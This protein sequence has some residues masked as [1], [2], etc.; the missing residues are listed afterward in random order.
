MEEVRKDSDVVS[1]EGKGAPGERRVRVEITPLAI[2]IETSPRIPGMVGESARMR[3]LAG[4]I[5]R[6]GKYDYDVLIEGPTG[7]GKTVAARAIYEASERHR[8]GGPWVEVNSAAFKTELFESELFGY[9]KGAFTG[10]NERRIGFLEKA[11][12]GAL[13]LDEIGDLPAEVQAKLLKALEEGEFYRLGG[14]DPIKTDVRVICAT[15]RNL[16]AMIEDGS[17]REDLYYRVKS[18]RLR[19]PSLDERREDIPALVREELEAFARKHKQQ[20]VISVEDKAMAMLLERAWPGNIRELKHAVIDLAVHLDGR[21]EITTEDVD[22]VLGQNVGTLSV[23]ERDGDAKSIVVPP[24]LIGESVQHYLD[25][26]L[27]FLYNTLLKQYNSA[28]RAGAILKA[29]PHTLKQRLRRAE[30]R[31][32]AAAA[33]VRLVQ[34]LKEGVSVGRVKRQKGGEGHAPDSELPM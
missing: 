5:L 24:Y 18:L 17:F 21:E 32:K 30:M 10:A 15:K 9:E 26:I 12:G 8:K 20:E 7:T 34:G 13:F 6:R 16:D 22:A 11:N 1:G 27:I 33:S 23:G 14:R 25:R 4:E 28:S 3:Q 29:E 19:V 2:P 31:L